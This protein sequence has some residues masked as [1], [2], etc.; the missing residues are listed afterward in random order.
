V[1]T[2]LDADHERLRTQFRE[3]IPSTL[4]A[5]ARMFPDPRDDLE[6]LR[7]FE[8]SAYEAG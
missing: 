7:A 8:G 5:L 3:W 6:R 1:R 4:A 2:L